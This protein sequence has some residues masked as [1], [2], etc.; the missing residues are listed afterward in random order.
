ML[1]VLIAL[2]SATIMASAYLASRDNSAP[3]GENTVAA[4]EARWASLT[5]LE[6]AVAVLET[7]STWRTAH[8]DGK[9]IDDMAIGNALIDLDLIDLETELPPGAETDRIRLTA[10][11]V[12]DGVT[13]QSSAT[14]VIMPTGGGRVDVDLS[15]FAMYAETRIM[16][17][18]TALVARWDEAPMS[19]MGQRIAIGS[20]AQSAGTIDIRDGADLIDAT[21]WMNDAASGTAFRSATDQGA[22]LEGVPEALPFPEPPTPP[23]PSGPARRHQ[24]IAGETTLSAPVQVT[25]LTLPNQTAEL[26]LE[27]GAVVSIQDALTLANGG[28]IVVSGDATIVVDGD[29]TMTNSSIVLT[30]GA[31][32]TLHV[33]GNLIM[34]GS[35]LGDDVPDTE[36]WANDGSAPYTDV[37]ALMVYGLPTQSATWAVSDGSVVKGQLYAPWNDVVLAGDSAVYGR[38]AADRISVTGASAVYFDEALA[39]EFGYT[40]PYSPVWD[41]TAVHSAVRGLG[42]LDSA[43]LTTLADTMSVKVGAGG[44]VL[45]P[46]AVVVVSSGGGGSVT[47]RPVDVDYTVESV[48]EAPEVMESFAVSTVRIRT[49]AVETKTQSAIAADLDSCAAAIR[50]MEARAFEPIGTYT[51]AEIQELAAW[52]YDQAAASIRAG[53]SALALATLRRI[54][55]RLDGLANPPDIMGSSSSKKKLATKL[56]SA[57]EV[58]MKYAMS[59]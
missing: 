22:Q 21:I 16:M 52:H 46:A 20:N 39:G 50:S 30:E 56:A 3:I 55:K 7:E 24:T 10:T 17:S 37:S 40:N 34:N 13:K 19:A 48:G 45:S 11:A 58:V 18:D 57:I 14:G 25:T 38:I 44:A 42:S 4:A 1:L 51:A 35:Y 2:A 31:T 12:V 23:A 59:S 27:D 33:G 28:T 47:P 26:T 15:E 6:L 43:A 53:D 49:G 36:R 5:G 9:L 8:T 41:G 32:L 54:E 29:L